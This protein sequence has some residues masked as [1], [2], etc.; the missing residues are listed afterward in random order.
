MVKWYPPPFSRERTLVIAAKDSKYKVGANYYCDG[1][2]DQV[3][4][5]D[6]IAALPAAGGSVFLREGTYTISDTIN[7][8]KS[9]VVLT[10]HGAKIKLADGTNKD[11]IKVG[12]GATALENIRISRIRLDGN[13]ANQTLGSGVF[14]Q[15]GPGAYINFFTLEECYLEQMDEHGIEATYM[16]FSIIKNNYIFNCDDDAIRF[17]AYATHNTVIANQTEVGGWDFHASVASASSNIVAIN[18]FM[19]AGLGDVRDVSGT[20]EA[21]RDLFKSRDLNFGTWEKV[22]EVTVS[23]AAVTSIQV[24]GLDLDTAKAYMI[25]FHGNNATVTSGA[26]Y[27][28]VN[29]DT[30]ITNYYTRVISAYDTIVST[31]LINKPYISDFVAGQDTYFVTIMIRDV[32]GY[33]RCSYVAVERDPSG[34]VTRTTGW[35]RNVTGN[36]TSIEIVSSV[37]SAIAIGSKLLIFK[38]SA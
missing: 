2:A 25:V 35:T 29:G 21:G 6:A 10:G 31:S 11:M 36:V 8:V 28:E 17:D 37:S 33:P 12:D 9:N 5:N 3:E 19:A 24:T 32:S 15:G 30:T 27:L 26:L 23:G 38:V 7:I 1:V 18:A 22:A 14:V 20:V 13:R 16:Q 4:I 34:L